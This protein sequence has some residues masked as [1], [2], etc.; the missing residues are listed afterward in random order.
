[1]I[2]KKNI[3]LSLILC[4]GLQ[5]SS[6]ELIWE[7]DF[8]G[9]SLNMENWSY[10]TGDGCPDLCGWGNNERQIYSEDYVEV[11]DGNLVLTADKD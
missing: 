1:M 3:I 2:K 10:E 7:E 6:Q 8:E 11:K 5:V 4:M 9:N